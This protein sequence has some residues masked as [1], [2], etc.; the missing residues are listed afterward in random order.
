MKCPDGWKLSGV[1]CYKLFDTNSMV[2]GDA[3]DHCNV[4]KASLASAETPEDGQ[5]I[6]CEFGGLGNKRSN[7]DIFKYFQQ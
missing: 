7:K 6:R 2:W 3:A 4:L 5:L 1:D